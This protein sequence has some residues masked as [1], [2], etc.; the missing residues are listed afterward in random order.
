MSHRSFKPLSHPQAGGI[1]ILVV[2]MLLVLLTIAAIGMSKNAF[3]EIIIS[4]TARQGSMARNVADSG[5]EWSIYWLDLN[6]SASASAA[7][8]AKILNS[9][10]LALLADP[11][12]SGTPW[13][14]AKT[15]FTS[16]KPGANPAITLP[17]QATLSGTSQAFTLGLTRMGKLPVT[18]MGQGLGSG[19]FTPATGSESKQA[20]DLWAVRSDSQVSIGGVVFSHAKEAWISTPVQ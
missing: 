13:D 7:A 17:D 2:L 1:T 15:G 14:A 12:K 10:K 9:L 18:D 5:I 4:G 8:E 11:T 16:Y 20:P 19:A 3:R 6:N